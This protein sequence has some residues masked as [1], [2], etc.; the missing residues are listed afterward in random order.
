VIV[1][2]E[3]CF[4]P[5]LGGHQTAIGHKQDFINS[6]YY[7]L[8]NQ[9]KYR[10]TIRKVSESLVNAFVKCVDGEFGTQVWID[11]SS[12]TDFAVFFLFRP[13]IDEPRNFVEI[14]GFTVS[15]A[16]CPQLHHYA[17]K[18]K[19]GP[20][21][22]F[23]CTKNNPNVTSAVSLSTAAFGPH[24]QPKFGA[25][26]PPEDNGSV[27]ISGIVGAQALRIIPR[28]IDYTF[29]G[30]PQH[31]DAMRLTM[32]YPNAFTWTSVDV[33]TVDQPFDE[34]DKGSISVVNTL[35]GFCKLVSGDVKSSS[36]DSLTSTATSTCGPLE[37]NSIAERVVENALLAGMG[38]GYKYKATAVVLDKKL[39]TA[40]A[41][42]FTVPNTRNSS[43]TF[44][45][46]LPRD[47]TL[48]WFYTFE[49]HM[50]QQGYDFTLY[51][52]ADGQQQLSDGPFQAVLSEDHAVTIFRNNLAEFRSTDS[53][54]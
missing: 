12:D 4:A 30:T 35:Y 44:M 26:K 18:Y 50:L 7:E 34:L 31:V 16:Q 38:G 23:Q 8:L 33:R 19:L 49:F 48:P 32:A 40:Q 22:N 21:Q 47:A 9:T 13:P 37:P 24:V 5:E 10:D 20:V 28:T 42:N 39:E 51:R 2:T 11:A 6:D 53:E 3:I 29:S 17:N 43:W 41:Q 25:F 14:T 1:V 54:K 45:N 52:K 36:K 15:H 27:T 46:N